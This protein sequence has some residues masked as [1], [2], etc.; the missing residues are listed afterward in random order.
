MR[1][2]IEKRLQE[3]RKIENNFSKLTMRWADFYLKTKLVPIHIS[4]VKFEELPDDELLV[5]YEKV[6]KR[7]HSQM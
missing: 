2:L 3:I 1:E 7:F 4:E 6:I 5:L